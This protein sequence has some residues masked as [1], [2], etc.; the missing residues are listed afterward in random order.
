MVSDIGTMF[1]AVYNRL[2]N[3]GKVA[4]IMSI[5]YFYRYASWAV[6]SLFY[7]MEEPRGPLKFKL[8]VVISLLFAARIAMDLQLKF[9]KNT[10]TLV[11]LILTETMGITLLLVPTG[12]L[13][14]TFIWYAMNPVLVA[15]SFLSPYVCWINLLFYLTV[16]TGIS[17]VFRTP[18]DGISFIISNNSRTIMV[19]ILITLAMQLLS[20]FSQKLNK[21]KTLL[22]K[23]RHEL[24][25]A[26]QKLKI[27]NA[28][29]HEAME[30]IMSLYQVVE[31][32]AS[33]D[34][35]S[36]LVRNFVEYAAKLTR[37]SFAFFWM[38][39]D[40]NNE[41]LLVSSPDKS[42][43]TEEIKNFI[44][45]QC[46]Q[47]K[48]SKIPTTWE[49]HGNNYYVVEVKS[50]TLKHGLMGIKVENAE[51]SLQQDK[52]RLLDFLCS[53]MAVVLER[54]HIEEVTNHLMIVEE[55]NRIA[56]E[57][58]DSVSQRLFS[59][60]CAIHALIANKGQFDEDKIKEQLALI[61]ESAYLAMRELRATIYSLSTTKR[62]ESTFFLNLKTYLES[63]SKL[64]GIQIETQIKGEEHLLSYRVK[65]ALY[66]IICEAT[67]NAIRH[68]KASKVKVTLEVYQDKS[69]LCIRDNG[70][71]FIVSNIK[72]HKTHGLGISNMKSLVRLL[73]GSF[74]INSTVGIGTTI[75]VTIPNDLEV[76]SK[77]GGSASESGYS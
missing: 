14:S 58:H 35:K 30:H 45:E 49:Y 33:Q 75:Q 19:F 1:G 76:F 37:T 32:F 11:A 44:I 68:G 5:I 64:N 10:K 63:M 34:D 60:V 42:E 43:D 4:E 26:N 40:K 70:E 2:T 27:A 59:M 31:A 65:K 57:M 18:Q 56:N 52:V 22:E 72:N 3:R 16:A 23:Q 21:Q 13:D 47:L 55:Q 9:Y 77:L 41:G 12:G 54:F 53:L 71:G 61:K 66:R 17:Y 8:G 24:T 48:N 73:H 36:Q 15:A 50:V 46:R 28:R 25:D 38:C 20:Q 74:D 69:V 7:L 6:T 29:V 62:G 39:H 67:G 51:E